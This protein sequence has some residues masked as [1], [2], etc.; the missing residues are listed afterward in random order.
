MIK[1]M[2]GGLVLLGATLLLPALASAQDAERTFASVRTVHVKASRAAEFVELQKQLNEAAKTAGQP[3]RQVWQE[4][5]GELGTFYI[6][7]E[8]DKFAAYDE[9][10]DPPMDKEA[11]AAWVDAIMDTTASSSRMVMRTHP[12]F[13][14]PA[15]EGA[16]PGLLILRYTTVAPGKGGDYHDWVENQLS[17][18]LKAGGATG[19]SFN[20]VAIGG[21]TN[22]W[23]SGSRIDSWAEL[24]TFGPL[25]DMS[26]EDRAALFA[27]YS[28]MVWES[29]VRVLRYRADMSREGPA[30]D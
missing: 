26:D 6:V 20:H 10:N 17:P 28:D 9:D 2:Y 8:L 1:K 7:S 12:E 30:E 27:N 3:G 16:E 23:I 4:I 25:A 29:D 19:V 21:N 24:D 13:S 11:W 14:I 15:D 22:L 5:R 18:A